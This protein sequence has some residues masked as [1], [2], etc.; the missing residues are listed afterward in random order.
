VFSE[1]ARLVLSGVGVSPGIGIGKCLVI[2]EEKNRMLEEKGSTSKINIARE[3]KRFKL[4]S[5]HVRREL[6]EI[7]VKTDRDAGK[8]AAAIFGAQKLILEDPLFV[9]E[10]KGRIFSEGL[11]A[12]DA[13]RKTADSLQKKFSS[14]TSEYMRERG[15]DV[16]DVS[17]RVVDAL[18]GK[19][20]VS[21]LM[22]RIRKEQGDK[23]VLV[24]VSLT[25][26]TI[27]Q[28]SRGVLAG[29]V[30]ETGSATSHLAIVAK[31]LRI[32]AVL[33]VKSAVKELGKS[34]VAIVDGGAGQVTVNPSI[35]ELDHYRCEMKSSSVL[36]YP[37][38][39][40]SCGPTVTLDGHSV[41]VFANVGDLEG[42]KRAARSGA[43]GV[44]LFRTEFLYLKKRNPPS[45][46][47]FLEVL[48][49]SISIMEGRTIIVRTLDI[50]GDKKPDYLPFHS[51]KNPA[52]GLRGIRF[53][54]EN[55]S[56]FETQIAA[57]LRANIAGEV[58]I[59]FPMVSTVKEV[60]GAKQIVEQVKSRLRER[61][62]PFNS[63]VKIGIMVETPAAALISDKL[64]T[65][66]NFFSIGTNDLVQYALAADRENEKVAEFADP[67][68]PSI[69]ALI[70]RTIR[71]GHERS[72]PVGL[73][74]EMASDIDAIPILLG[75]GLNEF[76][77]DSSNVET[78]KSIIRRLKCD[79]TR[80]VVTKVLAS[81]S[82]T[83]VRAY[84]REFLQSRRK[85]TS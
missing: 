31:S 60:R 56:L 54:L 6:Q 19:H 78:V 24:S 5:D 51:E 80:E 72:L 62:T 46:D 37:Q 27:A 13:V 84:S 58:W 29:I 35:T 61:N 18:Q 26:S 50:G 63:D 57:L 71:S 23:V 25:P 32:P 20:T 30:T 69:L 10:V 28:F 17:L 75:M 33:K 14:L 85:I 81:E 36:P 76:S 40:V 48:I 4:A 12:E 34:Q 59:M 43:E 52:L 42:V 22:D 83:E 77:V 38:S 15:E 7:K 53:C 9:D 65:E 3:A 11:L 70:E 64:A 67:L 2:K 66:V 47:E 21:A 8:D 74:G 1:L 16:R 82:A 45:E 44:G 79:E 41:Q 39:V 49:Q 55:P 73:C 68:E